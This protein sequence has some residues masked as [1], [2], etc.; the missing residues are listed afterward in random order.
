MEYLNYKLS[1]LA[2]EKGFDEPCL[3]KYMLDIKGDTV[4]HFRINY[5]REGRLFNH[6][7]YDTSHLNGNEGK[8]FLWSAPTH[9]Q[10]VDWLRDEHGILVSVAS[11]R[12]KF[13]EDFNMKG[14]HSMFV[15]K[16]DEQVEIGD[17]FIDYYD[18]LNKGIE[19]GLN[20]IIK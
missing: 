9:Q 12:K 7:G 13:A 2:K 20:L 1:K 4:P 8:D 3:A 11:Y 18:A 5:E 15:V 14:Q 17:E 6:N 10:M 19:E 16:E